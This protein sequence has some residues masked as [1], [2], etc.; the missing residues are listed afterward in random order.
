MKTLFK[1]QL[2][3]F[4]TV[5]ILYW[6]IHVMF[7]VSMGEWGLSNFWFSDVWIINPYQGFLIVFI[8]GVLFNLFELYKYF[9]NS[10]KDKLHLSFLGLLLVSWSIVLA[11]HIKLWWLWDSLVVYS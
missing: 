11:V 2:I 10:I 5:G 6:V 7:I 3:Y 1:I 9:K 8:L 4:L